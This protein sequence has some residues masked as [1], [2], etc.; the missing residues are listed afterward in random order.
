MATTTTEP[1][2]HARLSLELET[3]LLRE[4]RST[5]QDLNASYFRR[6]LKIPTIE[7]SATRSVTS[8]AGT[9]RRVASRSAG[10]S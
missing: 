2:E 4:L 5:Y 3:A 7:S 9:G 6:A 8:D 1:T 10:G